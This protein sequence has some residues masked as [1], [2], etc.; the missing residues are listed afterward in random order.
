MYEVSGLVTTVGCRYDRLRREH[1]RWHRDAGANAL[2]H[3]LNAI[4]CIGL[5]EGSI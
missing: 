5:N 4:G 2:V 3:G 1:L